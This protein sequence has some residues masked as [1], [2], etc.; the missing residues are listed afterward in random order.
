M[1]FAKVGEKR[2]HFWD[3]NVR[4]PL[5]IITIGVCVARGA[6]EHPNPNFV[7]LQHMCNPVLAPTAMPTPHG[8]NAKNKHQ[9]PLER[10]ETCFGDDQVRVP[11]TF[12]V[13]EYG[14]PTLDTTIMDEPTQ[15]SGPPPSFVMMQERESIIISCGKQDTHKILK[16]E[17]E[18]VMCVNEIH[19]LMGASEKTL[20]SSISTKIA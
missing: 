14:A 9:R 6:V 2:V 15:G 19:E 4:G 13:Q 1:I 17:V 5:V 12:L 3:T 10:G 18:K 11:R 16:W 8:H 20:L 7:S